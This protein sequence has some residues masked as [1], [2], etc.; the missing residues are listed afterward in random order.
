MSGQT[1]LYIGLSLL[2]GILIP[3][4]AALSGAMGRT[5]ANPYA[6]AIITAA[7]AFV[8]VLSFSL[9]TGSAG[10]V[11]LAAIAKLPALQLLAG[12]GI[13]FYILSITYVGPRFGIGN[14]VM[15]VVAAQI[16]SAAAIDQ[17]GL[18]G[19]PAKP[20]DALRALGVVIMVIGVVIAQYAAAHPNAA[21]YPRNL[22]Q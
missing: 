12:L 2:A 8:V 17:F 7:G 1:L 16:A 20:I 4:A 10:G 22:A 13:A 18:F 11:N 3:I 5:L 19:A 6:A 14:A 15:L 21:A 9:A